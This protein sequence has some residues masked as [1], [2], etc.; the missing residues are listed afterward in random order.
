MRTDETKTIHGNRSFTDRR[1]SVDEQIAYYERLARLA[2]MGLDT[3]RTPEF[4]DRQALYFKLEKEHS[5]V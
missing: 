4:Y 5:Y 3:R 2:R 1:L